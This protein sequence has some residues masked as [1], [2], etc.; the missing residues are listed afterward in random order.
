MANEFIITNLKNVIY[1]KRKQEYYFRCNNVALLCIHVQGTCALLTSNVYV[2]RSSGGKGK[3]L[4]YPRSTLRK[5]SYFP[6]FYYL[7]SPSY[8]II[9]K[10]WAKFM[11]AYLRAYESYLKNIIILREREK[12]YYQQVPLQYTHRAP[13]RRDF[14]ENESFFSPPPPFLVEISRVL[15]PQPCAA[16]TWNARCAVIGKFN[17]SVSPFLFLFE[18][19][20]VSST[21]S[22]RW[23]S[24]WRWRC[25][26][27]SATDILCF[28][29]TNQS[30][31]RTVLAVQCSAVQRRRSPP[32][33]AWLRKTSVTLYTCG[34]IYILIYLRT[35]TNVVSIRGS[36]HNC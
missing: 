1:L 4:S 33:R 36:T 29:P 11:K 28:S 13:S 2:R 14:I 20:R 17:L 15:R 7:H 26:L 10:E 21:R 23:L 34:G 8:T 22:R 16:F 31:L 24:G 19:Q 18:I 30:N 9:Y 32:H 35:V 12:F 6:P 27:K 25:E 3:N 5:Y